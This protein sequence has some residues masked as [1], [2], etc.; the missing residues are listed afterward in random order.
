MHRNWTPDLTYIADPSSGSLTSLDSGLLVTP[1]A[2][3]E[4]GYV[5][6]V[7]DQ[8]RTLPAYT[9]PSV[10]QSGPTAAAPGSLITLRGQGLALRHEAVS[11]P[12]IALGGVSAWIG[13]TSIPMVDASPTSIQFYLPAMLPLGAATL[14]LTNGG[15]ELDW[16]LNLTVS[17]PV[18]LTGRHTI[19]LP[20]AASPVSLSSCGLFS[21][22]N[23]PV[24]SWKASDG[25]AA[26]T[27]VGTGFRNSD[28]AQLR[29]RIGWT[30]YPAQSISPVNDYGIDSVTV[31]MPQA[32]AAGMVLAEV[33]LPGAPPLSSEL[34]D[35]GAQPVKGQAVDVARAIA[36][37]GAGNVFWADQAGRN[38]NRI[39]PVGVTATVF[40]TQATS[41]LGLAV[42]AAGTLL[43]VNDGG[44]IVRV[45]LADGTSSIVTRNTGGTWG[46]ALDEAR[47]YLYLAENGA[48]RIGR[49]DL[50]SGVRHHRRR[51]REEVVHLQSGQCTRAS[52]GPG[53]ANLSRG[54]AGRVHLLRRRHGFLSGK[55]RAGRHADFDCGQRD[56]RKDAGRHCSGRLAHWPGSR[57][58]CG[59]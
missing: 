39:T 10:I 11:V 40:M 29:V 28:P 22:T 35:F 44:N 47:N 4:A 54:G 1:P 43:Y 32:P 24:P 36:V 12:N 45:T 27:L 15:P 56:Q 48:G 5:P 20:G 51:Q 17:A 19:T 55:N 38:V 46:I 9:G 7:A 2:G 53:H 6:V 34:F 57:S 42:N 58:D 30:T 41:I 23:N 3:L 50:A 33:L 25:P 37:D 8:R 59:C 26:L 14:A 16:P 52:G 18:L 13:N 21:C 31:S 49:L